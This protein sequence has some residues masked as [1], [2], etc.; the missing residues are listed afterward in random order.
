[1]SGVNHQFASSVL[2]ITVRVLAI[3][4]PLL[5]VAIL[6]LVLTILAATL[7]GGEDPGTADLV[8]IGRW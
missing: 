8:F 2:V 6:A 3:T 1:M 4:L 7:S 5:V